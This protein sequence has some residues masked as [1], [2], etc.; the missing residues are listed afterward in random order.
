MNISKYLVGF[1]LVAS[2]TAFAGPGQIG[3][4]NL[5]ADICKEQAI[6]AITEKLE[7]SRAQI[8]YLGGTM[9]GDGGFA[10]RVYMMSV[11]ASKHSAPIGYVVRF[12][13]DSADYCDVTPADAKIEIY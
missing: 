10:A 13:T 11:M 4:G 3:S 2:S 12:N 7:V 9:V 6:Q 5:E 8:T 1:A